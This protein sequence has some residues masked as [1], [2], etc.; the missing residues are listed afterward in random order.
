MAVSR[1][2]SI[3]AV[4]RRYRHESLMAENNWGCVYLLLVVLWFLMVWDVCVSGGGG[5]EYPFSHRFREKGTPTK[6]SD[7][8]KA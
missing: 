6:N 2:F 5:S 1:S 8:S 4:P 3:G 7:I